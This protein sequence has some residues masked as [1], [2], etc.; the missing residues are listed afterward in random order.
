MSSTA[1][2]FQQFINA[3]S[4]GSI[5]A[6]VTIGL[7]MVFSILRLINFAHG[8]LMMIGSYAILMLFNAGL[9]VWTAIL[10][11]VAIS[12]ITGIIME[13]LC[14]RPLRGSAEMN[15]L[16][17]SF[18]VVVLLENGAVL[19]FGPNTQ[20]FGILNFIQPT[21]AV[22]SL[23]ISKIDAITVVLTLAI[24]ILTAL[25]IKKTTLGISMRAVADDL[26]AS[27]LVGIPLNRVIVSAFFIGSLFAGLAGLLW[28]A[29][30]GK[31]FPLMGFIPVV[32][33]FVAAVIG[34]FG[35]IPGAVI[36]G[37]VLGFAEVFF[38]ALLPP[39][40]QGYRDAFVFVLLIIIL[41][42]RPQG[43]LGAKAMERRI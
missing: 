37:Y 38:V 10:A 34:G 13:R 8:D 42:V 5:Y 28:S 14:Y 9:P 33:A 16:L 19:F 27:Q 43:I 21:L 3:L 23:L 31:I 24:L 26:T 15:T 12:G 18:A 40:F 2:F 35:S 30:A 17:T 22:G 6:L 4:L 11:G 36:G 29:R 1:Y 39:D 25:F 20:P 7:A 32:K 41:L